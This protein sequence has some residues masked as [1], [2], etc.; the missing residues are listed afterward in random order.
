MPHPL[1][2]RRP[3]PSTV[4]PL[5]SD[6]STGQPGC[7]LLR[8]LTSTVLQRTTRASECQPN[9]SVGRDTTPADDLQN[10]QLDRPTGIRLLPRLARSRWH[11]AREGYDTLSGTCTARLCERGSLSRCFC[12]VFPCC[13]VT[14]PCW[15]V[16]VC[17]AHDSGC[18]SHRAFNK[19]KCWSFDSEELWG[20]AASF[21][22]S[23]CSVRPPQITVALVSGQPLCLSFAY[24]SIW[25]PY[26]QGTM[27]FTYGSKSDV[28]LTDAM[29]CRRCH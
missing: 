9:L 16:A 26:P 18:M 14:M 13:F 24:S 4:L 28:A 2:R 21:F 3:C 11:P 17:P 23:T 6:S 8:P 7:T 29:P 12:A 27:V 1:G 22:R 20:C 19:A 5:G 25:L 10:P 15:T